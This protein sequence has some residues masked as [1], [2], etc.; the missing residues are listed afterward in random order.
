L[1]AMWAWKPLR[2]GAS[3]W[4]L[5]VS[6]P[7]PFYDFLHL[8]SRQGLLTVDLLDGFLNFLNR[9]LAEVSDPVKSRIRTMTENGWGKERK[10][11]GEPAMPILV[12]GRQGERKQCRCGTSLGIVVLAIH[13][14]WVVG[15]PTL[16]L[17]FILP[18]KNPLSILAH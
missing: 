4:P 16:Y 8:C 7:S 11:D 17:A 5:P 13:F 1:T 2:W 12:A 9:F 18:L 10:M 6:P 15:K 14:V 3:G